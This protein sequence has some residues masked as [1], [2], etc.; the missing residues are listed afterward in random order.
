MFS[1]HISFLQKGKNDR[2]L[3]VGIEGLSG[4]DLICVFVS[5][6]Y[7]FLSEGIYAIY[8]LSEG[9]LKSCSFF[10]VFFFCLILFLNFIGKKEKKCQ[11]FFLEVF[12]D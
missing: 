12:L 11:M 9:R 2:I 3:V 7:I 10:F 6:C 4:E 1:V 8:V 5:V